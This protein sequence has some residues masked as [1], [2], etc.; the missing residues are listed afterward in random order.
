[1]LY[2]FRKQGRGPTR[3]V[4]PAVRPALEVLEDRL[5]PA[6]LTVNTLQDGNPSAF[7]SL[8]EAV[9]VVNSGSTAGLTAAQ[10]AQVSGAVGNND[11]IQIAAGLAGA[12]TLTGG[13]ID[14]TQDVTINGPGPDV[15]AVSGNGA[16]RI[17]GTYAAVSIIGLTMTDGLAVGT[18]GGAIN[19]TGGSLALADCVLSNNLVTGNNGGA[20]ESNG[21][22]LT[23]TDCTFT[24]NSADG[25][26]GAIDSPGINLTVEDSTFDDNLTGA[27]GG[28]LS[29]GTGTVNLTNC[30]FTAN[31]ADESG[32]A[33]NSNYAAGFTLLNCTIADNSADSGGGISNTGFGN[34]TLTNTIVADNTATSGNDVAGSAAS[35]GDCLVKD[36]D[37][38]IGGVYTPGPGD[39]PA[40]TDPMLGPLADNGGPTQTMALSL[41]SPAIGAGPLSNTLPANDQL[42]QR[43][44]ARPSN[45]PSDIGAF[46]SNYF[47]VTNTNDSG[48]GSLRQAIL[49]SNG[50]ALLNGN[51]NVIL[52][53]I[54][55]SGV[56]VISPVNPLPTVTQSSDI[57]GYSQPGATP[58]SLVGGDNA[59][60]LIRIDGANLPAGSNGLVLDAGGSTVGG[61]DLTGFQQFA[62]AGGN[63]IEVLAS[64][65]T[66][67]GNF[68]GTDPTGTTTVGNGGDGVLLLIVSNTIVGGATAAA[69]NL[70]SG[71]AGN[72]VEISGGSG[73]Q[74]QGNF[75][76]TDV[77]GAPVLGNGNDGILLWQGASA[78]TVGGSGAAANLIAGNSAS[79]VEINET[80]A[81]TN[82]NQV[83]G[84]S[85]PSDTLTYVAQPGVTTT[86]DFSAGTLSGPGVSNAFAG[87]SGLALD[88]DGGTADLRDG[89]FANEVE[90][91]SGAAAGSV[92]FDDS[93]IVNYSN[94]TQVDDTAPLIGTATYNGTAAAEAI[95]VVDG[96]TIDG[97]QATRLDSGASGDFAPVLFANKPTVVVNG[98][99]GADT[100][101]VNNPHPGAGLG[102]LTVQAGPDGTTFNILTAASSVSTAVVGGAGNDSF[103]VTAALAAGAVLTIDGGGGTN[104]LAFDAQE[105]YAVGTVP[106]ALTVDATAQRVNYTNITGL[107]LNNALAVD[108]FYGPDTAD[109]ATA[110]P[111]S[112]TAEER[113]VADT[114]FVSSWARYFAW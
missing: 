41:G 102:R 78:N 57:E 60:L 89:S 91:P 52:F 9:N 17:F 1:M 30:T 8:R 54:P 15:L 44:V 75:I 12:I 16:G 47:L 48:P 35:S 79:A 49:D 77:N 112:L 104:T 110:L 80:M 21:A 23:I 100:F 5:A 76:G 27:G 106:G 24:G 62:G 68:I 105:Q 58:N 43:G 13:E 98:V 42:D 101:T 28:A 97:F 71:N 46:Q 22:A 72:G 64:G 69:S 6:L 33:I 70:I 103:N 37:P 96:G 82:A 29:I 86:I 63:G 11:T 94:T 73:N 67:A 34:F 38:G 99:A 85:R 2:W 83:Q 3:H 66:V 61:L 31:S 111:P 7:L 56:Q 39:L 59:D 18:S 74:V 90:A 50:A 108:A 92:V 45:S 53:D 25:N 114:R 40:G 26:G 10:L 14:I 109:R 84:L 51:P 95:D 55:G 88:A 4:R 20:I 93:F 36:T 32:G 107:N 113:F 87:L 19:V 81:L 65:D